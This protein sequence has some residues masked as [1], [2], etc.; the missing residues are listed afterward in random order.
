V[1]DFVESVA[2]DRGPTVDVY[3]AAEIAAASVLAGTSADQGSALLTV[4]DFRPGPHR[5]AGQAPA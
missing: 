5:P 4:P 1:H 3:R 2:R